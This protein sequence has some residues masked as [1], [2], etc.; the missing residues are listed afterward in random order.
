MK[1]NIGI[2]QPVLVFCFVIFSIALAYGQDN[3]LI[4][5]TKVSNTAEK[6]KGI[7]QRSTAYVSVDFVKIDLEKIPRHEQFTL[8]FEERNIHINKKRIDKSG[9]NDYTFIGS[10]DDGDHILLSVM[11]DDVQGVIE[12]L[13]GVFSIFTIEENEYVV[14]KVNQSKLKDGCENI[15]IN[16]TSNTNNR[17]G[18]NS[19]IV[20]TDATA[21]PIPNAA[22]GMYYNCKIRVLVLYTPNALAATLGNIR[23][24]VATAVSLSNVSFSNSDINYQIELAY[25]GATNYNESGNMGTDLNNVAGNS[26]T[27][28]NEVHGLRDKYSADVVVLLTYDPNLCGKA[29]IYASADDAFCVVS[30]YDN[31]ITTNYSFVH[32][33]GHLL[34][35]RHDLSADNTMTPFAY[36]HGHITPSVLANQWRTIMAYP[37]YCADPSN[38][39]RINYWSGLTANFGK[40]IGN[41]LFNNNARVWNEQSNRVMAFRQPPNSVTIINSDVANFLNGEI[42][43]KQNVTTIG[44]VSVGNNTT[45]R[46][47]A[48]GSITFNPGFSIDQFTTLFAAIENVTDCGN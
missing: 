30:T 24:T 35:C 3:K 48:G 37:D 21:S 10:N 18:L 46:I 13:T 39:P 6:V 15:G 17:S 1:A 27:Y 9:I 23:N 16:K 33:I 43:A 25:L 11:G 20:E 41:T 12:T 26:D 8:E 45:L 7:L 14:I 36:G 38:C 32:E 4:Y 34:G 19:G 42:V 2:N 28:M 5:P 40:T 22:Q 31:C 47:I 29:N 44:T